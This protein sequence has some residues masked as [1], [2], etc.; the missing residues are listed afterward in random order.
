VAGAL[1]RSFGTAICAGIAAALLLAGFETATAI[2]GAS[3]TPGGA[4]PTFYRLAREEQEA[5][6]R[7]DPATAKRLDDQIQNIH[8]TVRN[9][10]ARIEA[11]GGA[12]DIRLEERL[13]KEKLAFVRE[14][15]G[16]QEGHFRDALERL[17]EFY[18]GQERNGD[19]VAVRRQLIALQTQ[20]SRGWESME[21][22]FD[23]ASTLENQERW[24]E[25]ETHLREAYQDVAGEPQHRTRAAARLGAN[26]AHQQRYREAQPLLEEAGDLADIELLALTL[27]GLQRWR[28]AEPYWRQ[29]DDKQRLAA[30]LRRQGRNAEAAR[31]AEERYSELERGAAPIAAPNSVPQRQQDAPDYGSVAAYLNARAARFEA[32]GRK[33]EARQ[34]RATARY[35]EEESRNPTPWVSNGWVDMGL[36]SELARVA[37]LQLEAG[38]PEEARQ[39]FRRACPQLRDRSVF[40]LVSGMRGA[41]DLVSPGE[42]FTDY[43]LALAANE[44]P[45]KSIEPEMFSAA[46]L[47]AE[48]DAGMAL[49]RAGARRFL[50]ARGGGTLIEQIDSHAHAEEAIYASMFG[51]QPLE[52][53]GLP[54][55]MNGENAIAFSTALRPHQVALARL[56]DQLKGLFPKYP[57]LRAPPPVTVAS[58]Q[59]RR[60]ED[61]ALLNDN[62]A[63]ILWLVAPGGQRGIVFAVSK[64]R[65]A[66]ARISLNGDEIGALVGKLRQQIDP[67]AYEPRGRDCLTGIRTF[68][69]EAAWRLYQALLGAPEIR[70]VI[71]PDSIKT[72]L[73]VPSG[74]LAQLPPGL[75]VTEAP[76][77]GEEG[78][79]S[80]EMLQATKWLIRRKAI[81]I[82]PGVSTLRALRVLPKSSP[83]P[84]VR[85]PGPRLFMMADPDFSGSGAVA[86]ECIAEDL[87]RARSMSNGAVVGRS[88]RQALAGLRPLPCTRLEGTKLREMLGGELLLGRDAREARIEGR[89]AVKGRLTEAEIVA[90]ATHGLLAGEMG[91]EE[92]ALALA[93][94]LPS[95]GAD[96]GFLTASE[97]ALMRLS[98]QWVLLSACNTAG[99]NGRGGQGLSGLSRAF[100]YA[101]AQALLASHWRV[102]DLAAEALVTKAVELRLG[103]LDKAE[104]VRRASLAVLDGE[105][106]PTNGAGA[107]PASWAAFTLIGEPR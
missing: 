33:E 93:A 3:A 18:E 67:C 78:G 53:T 52:A 89:G 60:G 38:R 7:G 48:S 107:H 39:S 84:A 86:P 97:I 63:L 5:I 65:S 17:A 100:F 103:G 15:F 36:P 73:I 92:P 28:E 4:E 94:P 43:T 19:A 14:S 79:A 62:E 20:T 57:E 32:L 58:L 9:F 83:P 90:F 66:W 64:E 76:V 44:K 25:A 96:D 88:R 37:R 49:N 42:C 85:R 75:L 105:I 69:R 30:N 11:A 10:D 22:R 24:A 87:G 54:A 61:S 27:E 55:G 6:L 72:L 35:F 101:G 46:Q 26:L 8:D 21:A 80:P 50:I 51:G 56:T 70:D 104:A 91:L 98:A 1:S 12:E 68:D 59:A 45:G 82:L 29:L 81:A 95:D 23:I 31:I 99:P 106:G 77:G 34:L 2:G 71:S 41:Q 74:P 102:N 40:D 47:G 13:L 16:E